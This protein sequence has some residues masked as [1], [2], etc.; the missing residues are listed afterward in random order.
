MNLNSLNS[1]QKR[2][3][4]TTEGRV[5]ILAGA[6]SGKT[7]VLTVR[8]AYLILQKNVLPSSI[9]GLTFTNKAAHE[10]RK[11]MEGL[12]S[13]DQ[14]KKITLSTFHS[15]C[16]KIL[17]E[18]IHYLGFT[19]EFTLW[20]EGDVQRIIKIIARDEL[21][22]EA[23]LPSL[24]PTFEAISKARSQG[25]KTEEMDVSTWH[26][27]FTKT[28]YKRL[29]DAFRA[30]N[31]L[32]FDSLLTET[33]NLF[34][35][36]PD[37]LKKW[38]DRYRYV[39]I[40]EYQD[41]NPIQFRLTEL[42]T[43]SH[44]NLCVV[45][46]DDQ[47]I[48]GWRGASIKN[49]LEFSGATTIKLEQ[50]FRSTSTILNAANQVIQH[51]TQ[52]HDKKL[53]SQ[54]G[55]G[56]KIDVF[57]TPSEVE[58]AEAVVAR[59][60]KMREEHKVGWSHFAILYRSNALSRQLE[61]A[62]LKQ[63]WCDGD[64]WLK[65]VP[66]QIFG[67]VEFYERKEVKDLVAYLKIMQNPLDEPS[68]L[69]VINYPRRG[70]GEGSLDQITAYNRANKVPLWEVLKNLPSEVDIPEKAKKGIAHFIETIEEG[71]VRFNERYFGDASLWLID[72]INYKK[73]IIEEVKSDKMQ[74]FKWENVEELVNALTEFEGKGTIQDF[75]S[76][77]HLDDKN[78]D[79][80]DSKTGNKISLMTFHSS[81]G[82]EFPYCFLVGLE[83]HIIPH[84]KSLKEGGLEEERRLM[85]VAITRAK[86]KLTISM[87]RSRKKMGQE[88][89]STPSRFLMDISKDLLQV[90]KWDTL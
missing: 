35:K 70:I 6:G 24:L 33:V 4:E 50:N 17:R 37:V 2:A 45:G 76:S 84:E 11:R 88:I 7:K 19:R 1:E 65:G 26:D 20:D 64:K 30:F 83:D 53:W 82:L 47:S 15:F 67:G 38:Q 51:N 31:G 5:L 71:K 77:S 3:V 32:D 73:A 57:H 40:D 9:L 54:K 36:F 68:I 8:M 60:V 22:I 18:D 62:L 29:L 41:T 66:Y 81:K 14:A 58:E 90:V 74:S 89:Q 28:V 55:E 59:I 21:G 46:D 80:D 44:N 16:L 27:D 86:D 52:R 61:M 75:L 42:L 79:T 23:E 43:R 34:E 85:Y 25:L 78:W 87:A 69:R 10:M 12:V 72:R 39:M 13:K 49:I 48:Y 63:M 56:N